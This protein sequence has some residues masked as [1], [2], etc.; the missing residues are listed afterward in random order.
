MGAHR[1]ERAVK[2]S[3]GVKHRDG[4]LAEPSAVSYLQFH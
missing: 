1:V 3:T 2:G 4:Q